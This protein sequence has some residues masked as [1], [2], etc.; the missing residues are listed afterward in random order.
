MSKK[1]PLQ[2]VKETHGSKDKLVDE[3]AKLLEPADGESAGD[4]K[5]RLKLVPN[6]KLLHLLEVGKEIESLGGKKKVVAKIA[7][8]KGQAK[9]T[10]FVDKLSGQSFPELLDTLK[11]LERAKRKASKKSA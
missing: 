5:G 7:E 11:S 3:V 8:L 2:I 4:F 1:T 6:R 9:D 10:Y